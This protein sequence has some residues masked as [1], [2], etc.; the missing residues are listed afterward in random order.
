MKFS[1]RSKS[2]DCGVILYDVKSGKVLEKIPF[3]E[4]ERMGYIY[5]KEMTDLPKVSAYLCWIDDQLVVD[6]RS[7]AFIKKNSYGEKRT[8]EDFKSVVLHDEFD[9]EMDLR[10]L[11]EYSQSIFYV[12]HVRGFTKHVSGNFYR[13]YGKVG[14]LERNR[15]D[16]AGTTACI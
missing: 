1:L 2:P 5:T 10:P 8:I 4:G 7:K 13:H 14:L 16:I 12:I 11:I 9:W 3:V 6:E 15:G